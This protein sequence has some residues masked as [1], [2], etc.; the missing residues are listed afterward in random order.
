[1]WQIV[2]VA[3]AGLAAAAWTVYPK[4]DE[5]TWWHLR[6]GEYVAVEHRLPDPDPF[7][8][9][10]LNE[11]T[12]WLAYSWLYE[13]GM[14][15]SWRALGLDG[16]ILF[17][18]L[19]SALTL[20]GLVAFL[21]GRR[22]SPWLAAGVFCLAIPAFLPYLT[23]RPW[24]ATILGTLATLHVVD[25]LR[26]DRNSVRYWWLV[27][28]FVVWANIHIQFVLGLGLLGMTLGLL[29]LDRR[30]RRSHVVL[31][32]LCA[33]ATLATPFHVRLYAV[34]WEYAT[35]TGALRMIQEL[36]PPSPRDWW[37][38]PTMVVA[39]WAIG[40]LIQRKLPRWDLAILAVGLFFAVRMQ[41]DGWFGFACAAYVI[42]RPGNDQPA[43]SWPF[44]LAVI[45][46]FGLV[47]LLIA[48][49]LVATPSV[50]AVLQKNYPVEEVRKAR[51]S[52]VRG[53]LFNHLDWGGYL[54][55]E[56]RDYP[57]WID[58]RTNLHG[59]DR[60]RRNQTV[61]NADDG[62]ENDPALRQAGLIVAPRRW[63]GD[64]VSLTQRLLDRPDRWRVVFAGE[65]AVVFAAIAPE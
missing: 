51:E 17:R 10:G 54:I 5:D 40:C 36:R 60:L 21:F 24:H 32:G 33:L 52:G 35:Q 50:E 63:G 12:P 55:W 3:L 11:R 64:D 18:A 56:L 9:T 19:L 22:A 25:G 45:G 58:G 37:T 47:R 20:S 41:R 30:L 28:V 16:L 59:D 42:L 23:E 39:V 43:R 65:V 26:H 53:P 27:P 13:L 15:G 7:S 46:A 2:L 31:V 44:A 14:Y 49:S 8:Q 6:V 29:L 38:W 34:V 48:T 57:V 1:M 4:I 62:W 61:W